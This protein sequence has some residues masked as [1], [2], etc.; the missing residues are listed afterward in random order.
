MKHTEGKLEIKN[1]HI[2]CNGKIIALSGLLTKCDDSIEPGESWLDMRARTKP[3]RDAIASEVKANVKRLVH[4]WNNF[5]E[6]LA[7]LKGLVNDL[8][9]ENG[10]TNEREDQV[11]KAIKKAE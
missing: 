10:Y 11:L 4:C 7:A 6:L 9:Q 3:E 8:I 1:T 2:Y 5:D